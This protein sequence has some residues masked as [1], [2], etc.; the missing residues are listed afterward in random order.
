MH[1]CEEGLNLEIARTFLLTLF[2]W[3][4]FAM[5]GAWLLTAEQQFETASRTYERPILFD[6]PYTG[7]ADLTRLTG[8]QV[9]GL[10]PY[11]L[12]GEFDLSIEGI[13]TFD[14]MTDISHY[15]LRWVPDRSYKI[16]MIYDSQGKVT[17]ITAQH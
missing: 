14:S 1:P 8:N 17:G 16:S 4:L 2:A 13:G 11:A 6:A 10:V 12:N 9:L 7:T 5:G 15:D 3:S